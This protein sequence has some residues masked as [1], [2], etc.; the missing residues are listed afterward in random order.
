MHKV[1]LPPAGHACQGACLDDAEGPDMGIQWHTSRGP[2]LML[3]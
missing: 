1:K 3:Q 2:G